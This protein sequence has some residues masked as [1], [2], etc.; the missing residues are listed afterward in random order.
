MAD[1]NCY[2]IRICCS[3]WSNWVLAL[4]LTLFSSKRSSFLNISFAPSKL[5]W[6]PLKIRLF[7]VDQIAQVMRM[8]A[9]MKNWE[10]MLCFRCSAVSGNSECEGMWTFSICQH[11]VAKGQW[12]NRWSFKWAVSSM[13]CRHECT[14]IRLQVHI[15]FFSGCSSYLICLL[16]ITKRKLCV[17]CQN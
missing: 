2:R 14:A 9:I 13:S 6:I 7:Q 17:L 5:G 15:F 11:I 10:L 4:S 1:K 3:H 12:R 8:M 16:I